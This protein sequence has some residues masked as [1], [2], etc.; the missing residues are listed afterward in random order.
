MR[1]AHRFIPD[2]QSMTLRCARCSQALVIDVVDRLARDSHSGRTRLLGRLWN[3]QLAGARVLVDEPIHIVDH[4]Y[5]VTDRFV[6]LH[7]EF[8]HRLF[9]AIDALDEPLDDATD[10][11]PRASV[12]SLMN[13]PRRRS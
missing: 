2:T 10:S 8:V 13:R 3:A 4:V 1:T 5:A 9:E 11:R 7:R 12:T 6:S